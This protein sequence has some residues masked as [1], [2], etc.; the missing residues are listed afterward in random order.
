VFPTNND[1]D[2]DPN[3]P[4]VD[5]GLE[6]LTDIL[7]NWGPTR[8]LWTQHTYHITNV[9]DLCEIP[10]HEENNWSSPP[11]HPYNNYRNNFQGV[12]S[13]CAPDLVLVDLEFDPADCLE[14]LDVSVHVA[15]QGCL[16]VG[17]GVKVTFYDAPNH[18]LGTVQT[19]KALVPG[20]AERV[21]LAVRGSFVSATVW[22]VVDDDGDGAGRLNECK[23]YNNSLP[24]TQICVPPR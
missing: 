8:P 15:N 10:V 24:K 14:E 16:G 7:D 23:E 18:P 2:W 19:K 5:A 3:L 21:G 13:F 11:D 17:P 1:L 20:A 6:V 4:P 22:A 9:G 12:S